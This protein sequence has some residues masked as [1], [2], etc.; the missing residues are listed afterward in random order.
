MAEELKR[1]DPEYC[2]CVDC[3]IGYSKPINTWT[4]E[5]LGRL[6]AGLLQNASGYEPVLTSVMSYK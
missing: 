2:G 4:Q 6:Y 3:I 5:D 1:I